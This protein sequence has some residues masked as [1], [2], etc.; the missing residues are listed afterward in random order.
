MHAFTGGS[1]VAA[2]PLEKMALKKNKER[3]DYN[4]YICAYIGGYFLF[5]FV[6]ES[7]ARRED[8]LEKLWFQLR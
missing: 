3:D 6:V 7:A 8:G 5:G 2:V 1:P 4:I